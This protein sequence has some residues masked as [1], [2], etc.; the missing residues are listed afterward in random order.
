MS[1]RSRSFKLVCEY[2]S[3]TP[4]GD[5][6]EE[7][8]RAAALP[9]SFWVAFIETSNDFLMGPALA[10]RFE[11]LALSG[12]V[13]T[14]VERHCHAV[15]RLNRSRNTRLR[16]EAIELASEL[17]RIDV[18]PLF[19]KGSAGLLSGLYEDQGARI[20]GDLDVLISGKRAAD[21]ERLLTDL[22]YDRAPIA[23]HPR[24][25]TVGIFVRQR[26]IAPI[27]LHHEVLAIPNQGLLSAHDTIEN[28]V[29]LQLDGVT[30]AIPS[31][32]H[33]VV[34]N[35]GHAQLNDYAY[36]YGYLPL[37]ALWDFALLSRQPA[38]IDWQEIYDR[39]TAIGERRAVD[40]HCLAAHETLN[41]KLN[42]DC[43][44]SGQARF[45]M[46]RAR[47]LT[48]HPP[49]QRIWFRCARVAML[50]R[51]ER[52]DEQL[53]ARLRHN[54]RDPAW[55]QRHLGIFWRG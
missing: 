6:R 3:L 33:Q 55:W 46:G 36:R 54:M 28:S 29:V 9:P 8:V 20:M 4:R 30:L 21:C 43:S 31:I 37:R 14:L 41:V 11:A 53:K 26:S 22:G 39:F 1:S 35:I 42:P 44:P 52:S 12:F 5:I 27:D 16:S 24:D 40:Y 48:N 49:L 13:P 45:L 34:L 47:F 15:L 50:L 17:N 32:T 2:L 25:K 23:R 7:T 19:L 51:R 10:L 38:R 18:V